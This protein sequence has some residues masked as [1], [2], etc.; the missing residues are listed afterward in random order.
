MKNDLTY[1]T[2]ARNNGKKAKEIVLMVT[3]ISCL[4]VLFL[5][6]S[7]FYYVTINLIEGNWGLICRNKLLFQFFG[8]LSAITFFKAHTNQIL[9]SEGH[10]N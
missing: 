9:V 10:P 3:M 7:G 2:C 1:Q 6:D 4:Y 8:V 5:W